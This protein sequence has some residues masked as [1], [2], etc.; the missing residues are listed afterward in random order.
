MTSITCTLKSENQTVIFLIL[1]SSCRP[2]DVAV[3]ISP[4][5]DVLSGFL[6]KTTFLLFS[7]SQVLGFSIPLKHQLSL[8]DS[9]FPNSH[10]YISSQSQPITS[11][12]HRLRKDHPWLQS[13]TEPPPLPFTPA[14]LLPA[15]ENTPTVFLEFFHDGGHA[16]TAPLSCYGERTS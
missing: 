8:H 5:P 4:S 12:K 13:T 2:G 7:L 11:T 9:H 1:F 16:S 15:G 6:Y 3:L 10:R 14:R